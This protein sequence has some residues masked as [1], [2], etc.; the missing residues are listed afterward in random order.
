MDIKNDMKKQIDKCTQIDRQ[1]ERQIDGWTDGWL[2]KCRGGRDRKTVFMHI[3]TK[4]RSKL[5]KWKTADRPVRQTDREQQRQKQT[6]P[7]LDRQ[8]KRQI[9]RRKKNWQTYV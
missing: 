7:Y 5:D 9:N 8:T 3:W 4:Y 1:I 6:K 2:D